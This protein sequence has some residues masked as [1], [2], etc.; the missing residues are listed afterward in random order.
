[1]P[2]YDKSQLRGFIQ[3]KILFMNR[4]TSSFNPRCFISCYEYV[5]FL[6]FC[7]KMLTY[8]DNVKP[9]ENVCNAKEMSTDYCSSIHGQ[10][11]S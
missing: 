3:T 4:L 6:P 5:F 10:L 11:V 7:I 9:Y 8:E 2:F 1:M